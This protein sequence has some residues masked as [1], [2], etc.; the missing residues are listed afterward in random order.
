MSKSENE[1]FYDQVLA[2]ELK[3]IGQLC[4]E[5]NMSLLAVVQ[6]D[7]ETLG[8]TAELQA[9]HCLAMTMLNHCAKSGVNV[10]QYVFGLL[11]YLKQNNL[12]YSASIALNT[13]ANL[14]HPLGS[15]G[16]DVVGGDLQGHVAQ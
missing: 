11:S 16:P 2:P 9:D 15:I 14:G 10:D 1:A 13:I 5:H 7:A 8:R 12:D 4:A 3:R 6:I